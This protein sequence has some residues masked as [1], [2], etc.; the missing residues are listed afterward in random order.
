M[1]VKGNLNTVEFEM[2]AKYAEKRVKFSI[3][4]NIAMLK[5]LALNAKLEGGNKV[6]EFELQ[7]TG[8]KSGW[9]TV[10]ADLKQPK[11]SL[12]TSFGDAFNLAF[13][14]APEGDAIKIEISDKIA[15]RKLSMVTKIS[16][17]SVNVEMNDSK[18]NTKIV[19]NG[20][21]KKM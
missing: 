2:S 15:G 6:G 4:S 12:S 7:Y 8:L 11:M 1:S 18:T 13:E 17:T 14:L 10:T 16:G 19:L 9:F 21:F 20:L 5:K 3:T